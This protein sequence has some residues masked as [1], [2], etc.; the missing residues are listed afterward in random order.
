MWSAARRKSRGGQPKYSDL[1]ITLFLTLRV[2]YHQ[3]LRQTQ[4]LMR[5]VARLMGLDISVP[6]F[7][8]LSRR[9]KGLVLP[10]A[11][12]Q[13]ANNEPVHLVVDSTGLKIFGAGEWLENKH[14]IKIK[15][16][17][18]RKLHLG[19]DLASGQIICSD[20]TTDDV[21]DPTALPDLLDQVDGNVDTFIADG[22]YDGTPTSNLL[23][24]RFGANVEVIIPPPR[25]AVSS[26]Q[27]ALN[28]SVRDRHIAEIK[29][30]GRMAWQSI[31]DY[32]RRAK[33]ETSMGRYKSIIGNRLR[34]RKL[35]NQKT[36]VILGCRILN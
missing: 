31:T 28:P 35:A 2:I 26:P 4:G 16:K 7:S 17:T 21:G 36:E 27:A 33:A 12:P 13:V 9:G 29:T 10:L 18:W 23:V 3:P 5:S 20:L 22:A 8:T 1:A 24:A 19:L 25:T 11:R 6:D 32:G 34:S 30:Q 14:K 15:R